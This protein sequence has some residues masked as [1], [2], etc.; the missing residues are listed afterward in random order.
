[1]K[2]AMPVLEVRDLHVS[3][4]DAHILR[5]VT[6]DLEAGQTLGVVGE[7]GCGKSMT[8]F[9]IMGMLPSPGRVASGSILLDGRELTTLR[10]S[11]WR[12]VR[13]EQIAL[14][15]QDPFTSLNPMM[16]VGHQIAEAL[17][18]HQGLSKRDAWR[19]SVDLL[20]S[21]GVPA[22]ESSAKKYPHQMSGGQRQRVV[23]A[24]AFA[25]NP[26]VLI[27]D[28]PTT[29]LDV[30]LQ[31]QILRLIQEMKEREKTAV[32][33]ISHDI[34]VIGSLASRIAV[35]YAGRIVETGLAEDVLRKP[36]HPYT[37]ALLGAMPQPGKKRLEAIAGQP[38]DLTNLPP[39]C[40]FRPR[41]PLRFD[42]CEIEPDL[43]HAGSDH[44]S[45]CWRVEEGLDRRDAG[46]TVGVSS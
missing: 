9:A 8:G 28:E 25:C 30:T 29:A 21:V 36:A 22:P 42:K 32:M 14:V 31:A 6:F 44:Y 35:F 43:L 11:E 15:M 41:C 23:I 16:R 26:K 24:I 45:A 40:S 18:L 17:I 19:R 33:L 27:A 38:P 1:M 12:K 5:G 3:I 34:G 10:P 13:G 46:D 20:G 2:S 4:G 7:S 39:G 37:R